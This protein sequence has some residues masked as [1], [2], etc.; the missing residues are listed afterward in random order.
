MFAI[1][2]SPP[3][4]RRLRG[5]RHQRTLR[6]FLNVSHEVISRMLKALR[7]LGYVRRERYKKWNGKL[8][9]GFVIFWTRLGRKV[10]K[11]IRKHVWP[12]MRR[13]ISRKF[14]RNHNEA[15]DYFFW[16]IENHSYSAARLLGSKTRWLYPLQ[17][18]FDGEEH[19]GRLSSFK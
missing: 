4:Y 17:R 6:Y 18:T 19:P 11:R 13:D 7:E 1:E 3:G 15:L 8:G 9:R 10:I 5:G 2:P 14:D 12:Q 16:E